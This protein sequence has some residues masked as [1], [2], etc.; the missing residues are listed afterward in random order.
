MAVPA[1]QN[2]VTGAPGSALDPSV[3]S[4]I[5][6]LAVDA[7]IAAL[8][9]RYRALLEQPASSTVPVPASGV[10]SYSRVIEAKGSRMQPGRSRN[11]CRNLH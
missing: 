8:K 5:M 3:L 4:E 10:Q 11:K 2:P 7:E 9:I 1:P 6:R